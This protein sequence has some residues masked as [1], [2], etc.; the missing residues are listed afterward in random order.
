MKPLQPLALALV[1]SVLPILTLAQLTPS[2]TYS[3]PSATAG[4]AS[5]SSTPNTQWSNVLGNSLWFYDAQRSGKLDQG[6]YGNRVSWRNDSALQDGSDWGLDLTGGWYDAGD[7]I[8]ATFPLGFTLFAIAWGAVTHG[9]GYDLANQAA[10][11]DGTLRWG[12]DWLIKCHPQDDVLF[13][14]VGNSDVDNAYWGGDQNIPN[15]RPAYPVNSS[16]PGTDVWASTS[17]AFSMASLLYTSNPSYNVTSSAAAPSGIANGTYASTLLSHAK[18]LYSV[19]NSTS[20][21]TFSDS[22]PAVASA[23]S[24]SGYG[25]DLA[26]AALSLALVT[27]SSTYYADAYRWYQNYSLSGTHAVWNWDSRT[28]ALYVLFAE[29][30]TARPGLATGAGLSTNLTGWQY[31]AEG[32]FD[33]IINGTLKNAYLTNGRLLYWSGDSDEASLNPAMAAAMLMFKYAPLASSSSKTAQYNSFAQ[34]QLDYLMGKNPMN[35]IYLVGQHPNSPQNPHSAMAAGGTNINNIRNSPPTEAHVLYGAMVGGPLAND[36]FW[37]WRDDWV[38]TEVALDYNAMIPT[39]AAMQL[40]NGTSD[41]Y[42]VNVQAGT[43][44]IPSGQPCDAALPCSNRLSG[45]AIAGIVVGIIVFLLLVAGLIWWRRK[46]IAARWR[47]RGM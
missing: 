4:L 20:Q 23:Y 29:A 41:P 27:N 38:Q 9:H 12:L 43:Y 25:D 3:P 45:G 37:D 35:A 40:V 34:S 39:L 16:A 5:S 11:L 13:V 42:Y 15:P 36:R 26:L 1:T 7:Y 19:A 30:A 6:T 24:S 33:K 28:P 14:Q 21:S 8:K 10:Y 18:T 31:E 46:H 22:V 44:S 47:K 2:P 17:S 32:W